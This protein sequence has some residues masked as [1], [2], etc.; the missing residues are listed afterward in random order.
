MMLVRL[1]YKIL[2]AGRVSCPRW[3]RQCRFLGI[4]VAIS[5]DLPSEE[6]GL[7]IATAYL[8]RNRT[9]RACGLQP[10]NQGS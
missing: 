10:G 8:I 3:R 1:K 9:G 7:S 2:A 6:K 5:V 4:L